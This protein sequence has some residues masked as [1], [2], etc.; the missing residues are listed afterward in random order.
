MWKFHSTPERVTFHSKKSEYFSCIRLEWIFIL[1]EWFHSFRVKQNSFHPCRREIFTP[2]HF[3][4]AFDIIFVHYFNASGSRN[5]QTCLN[6]LISST[7]HGEWS[8]AWNTQISFDDHSLMSK[9][10]NP[11]TYIASC[12]VIKLGSANCSRLF[13]SLMWSLP[14]NS[15]LFTML[16]I[17]IT[18]NSFFLWYLSVWGLRGVT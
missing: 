12:I 8:I 11:D 2:L 16:V 4:R 18:K 15:N 17:I 3:P 13:C 6:V 9:I 14:I 7:K 10:W 5:T 1:L